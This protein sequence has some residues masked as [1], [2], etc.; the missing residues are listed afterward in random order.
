VR[1]LRAGA[2]R[3][4]AA[5]LVGFALLGASACPATAIRQ[6]AAGR[7]PVG[8]PQSRSIG[9]PA[10]LALLAR[11]KH[12][13]RHAPGLE[14]AT[15]SP[16]PASAQARRFLLRLH[17]G[18]VIAEAFTGPGRQG[19]ALVARRGSPTFLRTA[20]TRCWRSLAG[21]DPRT[22][23]NL[24][25]PFPENGKL[26][27]DNNDARARQLVIETHSG[28]WFLASHV[29]A[30]TVTRKSFLTLTLNPATYAIRSIRVRTPDPAV[31][32]DLTVKPLIAAPSIP[33]PTP[34]C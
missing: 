34:S 24:G 14:L 12:A 6:G 19:V 11:V 18:I 32:A 20:G 26:L 29:A 21:S 22:L 17:D 10:A 23:R 15:T 3:T 1:I 5:A 4:L 31:R 30:P 33:R 28:F 16:R 13:Y 25:A 9:P 7:G 8:G 2:R 27:L